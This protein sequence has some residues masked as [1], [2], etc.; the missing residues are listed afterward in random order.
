[1][2]DFIWFSNS[3]VFGLLNSLMILKSFLQE[4]IKKRV[5]QKKYSISNIHLSHIA[6]FARNNF[7]LPQ[8]ISSSFPSQNSLTKKEKRLIHL[9][10]PLFA[11]I[12]FLPLLLCILHILSIYVICK[13]FE[14]A[15][16]YVCATLPVLCKNSIILA[17]F[18][19]IWQSP[20]VVGI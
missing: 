11:V 18:P 16:H 20:D 5:G 12:W 4:S 17:T 6:P 19:L 2:A 10:F 8:F 7:L 1:M 14:Q 15:L 13:L 3:S 9:M